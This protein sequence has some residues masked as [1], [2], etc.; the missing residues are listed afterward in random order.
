MEK[1][2]KDFKD[3]VD[4][5]QKQYKEAS[6]KKDADVEAVKSSGLG[7]LKAVD[8]HAKKEKKDEL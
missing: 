3:F 2:E 6:E 5:L 4:G 7:L 1:L 8:A